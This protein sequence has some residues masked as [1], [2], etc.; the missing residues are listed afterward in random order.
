MKKLKWVFL[1]AVLTMAA[2]ISALG[3][4]QTTIYNPRN[5]NEEIQP[6]DL[7]RQKSKKTHINRDKELPAQQ[8]KVKE[9]NKGQS[10]EKKTNKRLETKPASKGL[11][12]SE[13]FFQE[14]VKGS[15]DYPE[16]L[17]GDKPNTEKTE[18]TLIVSALVGKVIYGTQG[19]RGE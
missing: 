10:I 17:S 11:Y 16:E 13:D 19:I 14:S 18:L 7:V 1:S 4:A 8:Q 6:V 15:F 3:N 9:V 2:S 12:L 5:P